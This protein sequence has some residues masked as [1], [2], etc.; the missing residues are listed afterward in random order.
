MTTW[1]FDIETQDWDIMVCAVALSDAGQIVRMRE[2]CEVAAWYRELPESDLV[3]AH[4]GGRFDFLYLISVTP[5]LRWNA[6]L[7]GSS[8]V[9]C[10]AIGHAECRDS[11]RLFMA[12]LE[13]WCGI[14]KDVGLACICSKDCGGYCAIRRDM[15]ERDYQRVIAYCERD[16]EALLRQ[17]N[18]DVPRLADAGLD[19]MRSNGTPRGTVGSVAWHTAARLA[20]VPAFERIS[21]DD[22]G[23]GRRGYYGGRTEVGQTRARH[24]HRYDLHAAYPAALTHDVPTGRRTGVRGE[25]ASALY[26]AGAPGIWHADVTL[27]R[28]DLPQ[29]PHRYS[30]E[31]G[32]GRLTPQRLLWAT[33]SISGCWTTIELEAAESNGVAIEAIKRG[34]VWDGM[35][36]IYLP[37]VEHIYAE[38][39]KAL[40]CDDKRWGDLLKWYANALSGKLAQHGGSA[41]LLVLPPG[42]D[43]PDDGVEY[44]PLDSHGRVWAAREPWKVPYSAHPVQAAYLTSR[45]RI[46]LYNRLSRHAGSWLYCDTDSTYLTHSDDLDTHASRLG[47][48][49]YE[50]DLTD[51]TALAPKLYR[52]RTDRGEKVRAR[53]VPKATWEDLDTL[54]VRD[55]S[56]SKGS[57]P[58]TR[59]G[60]VVLAR[61]FGGAFTRGGVTR[62]HL[63]AGTAW[64]GTRREE[65]GGRTR[66]LH[67]TSDGDYV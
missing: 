2:D 27:P 15:C 40:D 22:Y 55:E 65:E 46:A 64:V 7:A 43:P 31:S 39:R 30:G 6:N 48:W 67:R 19:V 16:C 47:A 8:I 35:E 42:D 60:G 28:S 9:S 26:R 56:R 10:Q 32:R 25:R 66:P 12:S 63:D 45:V 1:A 36:P 52:F 62:R 3:L 57:K 13:R 5:D 18:V 14:E 21:T 44:D 50:G 61:R 58:V 41:R 29:L 23:E 24:G 53:G 54:A 51:W 20:G 17:W 59:D 33:G 37:Y 38:R 49:G 4:N 11:Y 34:S